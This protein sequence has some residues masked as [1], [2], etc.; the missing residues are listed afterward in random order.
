MPAGINLIGPASSFVGQGVVLREYA[1]A[2]IANGYPVSILDLD[3]GGG[4]SGHELSLGKYFASSLEDLPYDINLWVIGGKGLEIFGQKICKNE[5][6]RLKF[7]VASIWWELPDVPRLWS[8]CASAFDAV[9]AGSEFIRESWAN[10]LSQTPVLFAPV[11][12]EMPT[13][14][15]ADRSRFGLPLGPLL[16]YTGF[17][18]GSD[19]IR[20]NPFAAVEAFRR[21]FPLDQG[22]RLVVKVN[23]PDVDGKQSAEMAKL[24]E[25]INGDERVLLLRE[26][27]AHAD[28]LS[29][30]AS[31]DV[32]VSLHRA[33]GLGLIPLEAMRLGKAVVATGWSGNMTYMD[34]TNVGVVSYDM[35]PTDESATH[36]APSA[37]GVASRW[38]EPSVDHAASWLRTFANDK[39]LRR[40]YGEQAARDSQR[41]NETALQVRFARELEALHRQRSQLPAKSYERVLSDIRFE[42]MEERLR[43]QGTPW[44]QLSLAKRAIKRQFSRSSAAHRPA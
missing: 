8:K 11:P 16:I 34:H 32:I 28:L 12:L 31:C 4:R 36:Y 7:N 3:I 6:L 41:Y 42:V 2:L 24:Y 19:P 23:N 37:V 35:V 30:Y 9:I 38:A 29:L 44:R 5:Y 39:S 1:K 13:T 27:L 26:R 17:D 20:K 21:A 18:A 43:H 33:E 22:V 25:Q 10:S 14:T 40:A 15:A